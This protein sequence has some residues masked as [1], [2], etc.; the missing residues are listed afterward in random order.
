MSLIS[1]Q[2]TRSLTPEELAEYEKSLAAP[3]VTT[4]SKQTGTSNRAS[5]R[6]PED[7]DIDKI[8]EDNR[9]YLPVL[10]INDPSIWESKPV[11]E[12]LHFTSEVATET[13]LKNCCGQLGLKSACCIMDPDDMEHVLGP[14][15]EA[16]I[17]KIVNHFKKKG[18]NF[19]RSDVVIDFEEGKLLGQTFFNDHP[20]FK[21][22]DSYPIMRIQTFGPRF[23]CKF[24]NV[25]NG[26]CNVYSFRPEMCSNYLC[27][28]VKSNFL[29]KTKKGN[30]YIRV[31]KEKKT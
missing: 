13:C 4:P 2:G 20:V 25:H 11:S 30:T 31:D 8:V 28:Y 15:S 29:V 1:R 12:R 26:K 19:T 16:D 14:V 9:Y 24:L 6:I 23:A 18:F 10:H 3:V 22:E 27:S 7:A 5:L 17:K 21:R